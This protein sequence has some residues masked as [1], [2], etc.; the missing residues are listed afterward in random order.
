M[1]WRFTSVACLVGTRGKNIPDGSNRTYEA[2]VCCLEE[3]SQAH[4]RQ[5]SKFDGQE[6]GVKEAGKL[7]KETP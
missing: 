2:P 5:E 1:G 4:M 3:P 7:T 6:A